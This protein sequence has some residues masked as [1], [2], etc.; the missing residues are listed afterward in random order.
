MVQ[1][2]NTHYL[3]NTMKSY[4]TILIYDHIIYGLEY[5][6]Y[7][8]KLKI[9]NNKLIMRFDISTY[10]F[11]FTSSYKLCQTIFKIIKL[12]SIFN[13]KNSS[14]QYYKK[15]NRQGNLQKEICSHADCFSCRY[16]PFGPLVVALVKLCC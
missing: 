5:I 11:N 3:L 6:P 4:Q 1:F 8:K 7:A 15:S 9:P 16:Q 13:L 10:S 2:V 12:S 14:K